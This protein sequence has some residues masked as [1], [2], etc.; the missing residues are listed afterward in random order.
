ME[1]NKRKLIHV[2]SITLIIVGL[3]M[4][5]SLICSFIN[6]NQQ[7]VKSFLLPMFVCLSI[8]GILLR[9]FEK[10]TKPLKIRDCY[11]MVFSIIV[12]AC[13]AGAFPYYMSIKNATFIQSIFE[14]TAGF[15]T[16]SATVFY[17]PSMAPS[18][19]LW[20]GIE[21]W[22][23]GIAILVFILSILPML[24]IGDQQIATAEAHGTMLNKIAPRSFQIIKYIFIIYS[25]ITLIS[26]IYFALVKT[27]LF[28]AS[29][30]ALSTSSTAGILLHPEG[31]S[32]YNSF[33]VE[34]GV[35]VLSIF[36]GLSFVVYIH[37]YKRNFSEL[38]R[39]MEFRAF[40]LIIAISSTFIGI[41]LF[42]HGHGGFLR[43]IADGFFQVSSFAT[44]SGFALQNYAL[45]PST[46]VFV[47]IAVMLIGGCSASTTGSFKVIRFLIVL[48]LI[49]KGFAKRIHPRS[50]H[51]VKIGNSPINS[52]M[53]ISVTTFTMVYFMTILISTLIISI[54]N[55]DIES[56]L[57]ATIGAI[58]NSGISFGVV[59]MS[60]NYNVFH[61]L[62]QLFISFLMIVGRVGLVTISIIFIPS[63]WRP[64]RMMRIKI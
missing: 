53:V 28:D 7:Q 50:V 37:L 16:T 1:I 3:S 45:W 48:K 22:V 44:T 64:H 10:S 13:V 39:N 30:L 9:L 29:I 61:P 5:P 24:G 52:S 40:L 42:R 27:G 31:I 41:S 26:F 11:I 2:L 4:I 63:F 32:Y 18:L 34:L 17:E 12:T 49:G 36:S 55:L 35:S 46:C 51:S 19:I 15:T 57:G 60:G 20:K 6:N 8:G 54:Q 38:K 21:H 56:S 59:G 33:L 58:S 25:G 23:G 62:L 43:S 47:L 14:S